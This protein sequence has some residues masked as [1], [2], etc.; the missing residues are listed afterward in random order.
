MAEVVRAEVLNDCIV[1][2]SNIRCTALFG[3]NLLIH[4][5]ISTNI[6]SNTVELNDTLVNESFRTEE[7]C[8]LYHFNVGYPM[9]DNGGKIVADVKSITPRNDWAKENI[10]T[11]LEIEDDVPEKVETCYYLDLN[12]S[13]VAYVNNNIA[14]KLTITYPL[15]KLPCFTVWKSMA[16]G[17]YALGL[18]PCTSELDSGFCRKQIKAKESITFDLKIT[19][20]D[21]I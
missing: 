8:V 19:V 15:D 20:E 11:A 10:A 7:Y 1:V 17:D 4:R 9:L 2:E 6:G 21:L 16:S 12:K 14:R 13:E 5:K 3:K 18:E